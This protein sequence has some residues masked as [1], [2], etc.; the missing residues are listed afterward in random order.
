MVMMQSIRHMGDMAICESMCHRD[1][2]I[3]MENAVPKVCLHGTRRMGGGLCDHERAHVSAK[4][5]GM[6]VR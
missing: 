5:Q 2:A 6:H 1:D 4:Q 3:N